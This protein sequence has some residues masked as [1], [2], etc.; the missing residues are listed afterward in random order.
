MAMRT[1]ILIL[2]LTVA[3]FGQ[4]GLRSPAFVGSLQRP[5]ASG[6]LIDENFEGTGTP[7]PWTVAA[8]AAS[9]N[10]DNASSPL[11]GSQDMKADVTVDVGAY[12]TF[13]ASSELWAQFE[14]T[15]NTVPGSSVPVFWFTDTAVTSYL[16]VV[17]DTAGGL[18]IAPSSGSNS[19]TTVDAVATGVQRW[20]FFHYK[21]GTGA[22]ALYDVEFSTSSTRTGSGNKFVG[23]SNGAVAAD[24]TRFY[25]YTTGANWPGASTW[26]VDNVKISNTGWPP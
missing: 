9:P 7:S 10:F 6:L 4:S 5:A 22:N 21:K 14:I 24:M 3:C 18:F 13:A 12:A 26:Q 23:V 11:S 2:F 25:F 15:H 16:E 19:G 8:P 17:M 1:I 20:I